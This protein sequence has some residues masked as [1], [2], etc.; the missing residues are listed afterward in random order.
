MTVTTAQ[1]K[2]PTLRVIPL[3]PAMRAALS[4]AL[5]ALRQT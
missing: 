2:Q 1:T 4:E 3:E 5:D